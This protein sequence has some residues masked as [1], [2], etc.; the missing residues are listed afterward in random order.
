MSTGHWSMH[1]P[2]VVQDQ[3]VSSRMVPPISGRSA[4]PAF[5][6]AVATCSGSSQEGWKCPGSSAPSPWPFS[7]VTHMPPSTWC[8]WCVDAAYPPA[9]FS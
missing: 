9:S 7:A 3:R 6:T 4:P 5:S 8:A 2:Q 1:A